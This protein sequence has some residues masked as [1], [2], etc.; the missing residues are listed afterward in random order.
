MK[1]NL[2]ET[3]R[4]GVEELEILRNMV[5]AWREDYFQS[6]IPGGGE[7]YLFLCEDFS[8][9]IEEYIYPYIRRMVVTDHLNQAQAGEFLDYCFR[10]VLELKEYLDLGDGSPD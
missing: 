8:Q 1:Q 6:A 10:Q 5:L 3:R 7:D 4:H 9:E 2:E